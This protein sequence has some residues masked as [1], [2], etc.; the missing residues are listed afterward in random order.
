MCKEKV[1]EHPEETKQNWAEYLHRNLSHTADNDI[2]FPGSAWS[3][4]QEENSPSKKSDETI[5][6]EVIEALYESDKLDAS[7]IEVNVLNG[8]VSLSGYVSSMTQKLAATQTVDHLP[9]VWD[10]RNQLS[11]ETT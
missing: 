6:E 2:P 8:I 4:S 1:M 9:G 3:T 5:Y 11:I 7:G 10:V